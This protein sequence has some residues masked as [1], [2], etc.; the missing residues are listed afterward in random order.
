M[1]ISLAKTFLQALDPRLLYLST[2]SQVYLDLDG[3][4]ADFYSAVED[5]PKPIERPQWKEV[6]KRFP[7]LYFE[8][9][10]MPSAFLLFRSLMAIGKEPMIL[11]AIPKRIRWPESV[12]QKREWVRYY[13]GT[14]TQVFFGPFAQDKQYFCNPGDVLIDDMEINTQQWENRGGIGVLYKDPKYDY[15]AHNAN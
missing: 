5:I 6:K 14:S 15:E 1:D 7:N 4:L 8:L 3:V 9:D 13:F 2:S 11:T 12:S 10:V